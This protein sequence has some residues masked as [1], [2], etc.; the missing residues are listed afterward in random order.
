MTVFNLSSVTP[1][2]VVQ[3]DEEQ[4]EAV[5]AFSRTGRLVV[6]GVPGSGLTTVAQ[7]ALVVGIAAE[8]AKAEWPNLRPPVMVV[9]SRSRAMS[10][11]QS[12]R[13]LLDE[14]NLSARPVVTPAALAFEVLR[15]W[16]VERADPLP[17]PVLIT[18]AKFDAI[19]ADLITRVP[20]PWPA[21]LTEEVRGSQ[22]FRTESRSLIEAAAQARLSAAQIAHL[23]KETGR[24]EWVAVA[25]I[26]QF[27]DVASAEIIRLQGLL[28]EGAADSRFESLS[29]IP[30]L[31]IESLGN[32]REGLQLIAPGAMVL[33]AFLLE[34]WDDLAPLE[35]VN[36]TVPRWSRIVIDGAQELSEAALEFTVAAAAD[37]PLLITNSPH[38]STSAYRGGEVKTSSALG[39]RAGAQVI[40]LHGQHRLSGEIAELAADIIEKT[41]DNRRHLAFPQVAGESVENL[42]VHVFASAL[43]EA[44][45][46]S[47]RIRRA[48]LE[49]GVSYDQMAVIVRSRKSVETL[50]SQLR[51]RGIPVQM[52]ASSVLLSSHPVSNDLL[53]LLDG[54]ISVPELLVSPLVGMDSMMVAKLKRTLAREW[55]IYP[56]YLE[57]G[58]TTVSPQINDDVQ[59]DWERLHQALSQTTDLDEAVALLLSDTSLI[60]HY[61]QYCRGKQG[62]YSFAQLKPAARLLEVA[63]MARQQSPRLGLSSLWETAGK[64]EAWRDQAI[65]GEEWADDYLDVVTALLRAADLWEQSNEGLNAAQ[66]ATEHLQQ[67]IE[68]TNLAHAGIRPPAVTIL[69]AAA[70]GGREWEYVFLANLCDGEWP[71]L[72]AQDHILGAGDLNAVVR[73]GKEY[74]SDPDSRRRNA[75][76]D[77]LRMLTCAVSRAR[78]QL[79]VTASSDEQNSPSLLLNALTPLE[80][81]LK[82]NEDQNIEVDGVPPAFDIRGT[83]ARLRRELL[84]PEL[85]EAERVAYSALLA[86]IARSAKETKTE[87]P[88]PREAEG[89]VADPKLWPEAYPLST[90]APLTPDGEEV[91]V[92]PSMVDTL[93]K[94]PLSWYTYTVASEPA[95][96]AQEFGTFIHALAEKYPSLQAARVS[97]VEELASLMIKEL[98]EAWDQIG[99]DRE[100]VSG[101]VAWRQNVKKIELLAQY[102][103]TTV[104]RVHTEYTVDARIGRAH[105]HGSVD[106]LEEHQDGAVNVTDLKTGNTVPSVKATLENSQLLAYQV[107]LQQMGW[108]VSDARLVYTK[109]TKEASVRT[110]KPLINPTE[111]EQPPDLKHPRPLPDI[112]LLEGDSQSIS[113]PVAQEY[114]AAAAEMMAG[115]SFASCGDDRCSVCSAHRYT[116][117]NSESKGVI[118]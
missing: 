17:A 98:D 58:E 69:T 37:S 2:A 70:S 21:E 8:A 83:T 74:R 46:L 114:I 97:S 99:E 86:A 4:Q 90:N 112:Q 53:R 54:S 48:H 72:V 61:Q 78:A 102:L 34:N 80:K 60:E 32:R 44:T 103:S 81:K 25:E 20:S 73:W 38:Q 87:S 117:L 107:A 57:F 105:I 109:G 62:L 49:D 31:A 3:L 47:Q 45:W 51:A 68:S 9:G 111:G 52:P 23:G 41:G 84:N 6:E 24:P 40:Q 42:E 85:G 89:A 118:S 1:T 106:R 95:K 76:N 39:E 91:Y 12:T 113:L 67:Q 63:K 33:A 22:R 100:T 66:F 30:D 82:R 26:L 92:S 16:Y 7:R 77:E 104:N 108:T 28:P 13:A 35:G 59:A 56:K 36:A 5:E 96:S 88:F 79:I 10:V 116:N 50:F 27:V 71:N 101:G 15:T 11:Q 55:R 14:A 18:G 64:A 93:K 29:Q 43:Q 115:N 94:C 110:Q 19:L 65:S 75:L